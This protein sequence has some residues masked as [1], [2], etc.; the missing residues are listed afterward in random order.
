MPELSPH[1]FRP[2]TQHCGS[3]DYVWQIRRSF[4][5]GDGW[6]LAMSQAA[7]RDR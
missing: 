4:Q 2:A 1:G 6:L 7:A 5:G 3:T